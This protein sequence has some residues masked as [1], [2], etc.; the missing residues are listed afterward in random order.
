E[1]SCGFIAVKDSPARRTA[2]NCFA[3]NKP[4]VPFGEEVQLVS[5]A[6]LG[7]GEHFPWRSHGGPARLGV[8]ISNAWITSGAWTSEGELLLVDSASGELLHLTGSGRIAAVNLG[9][10]DLKVSDIRATAAGILL[11]LRDGR[12]VSFDRQGRFQKE[13][14]L[15]AS[16]E[17]GP[18]VRGIF[19]WVPVGNSLL[20]FGDVLTSTSAWTSGWMQ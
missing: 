8:K 12:F 18:G 1:E 17:I 4:G 6:E 15:I 5:M 2:S 9:A 7:D 19:N 3:V 13:W 11:K 20:A 14:A 10:Q 16:R